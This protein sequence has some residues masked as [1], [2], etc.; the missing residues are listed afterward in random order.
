MDKAD[1]TFSVTSFCYLALNFVCRC[2]YLNME[3]LDV[4]SVILW[5]TLLITTIIKARFYLNHSGHTLTAVAIVV[6]IIVFLLSI[7]IPIINPIIV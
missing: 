7:I 6:A 1:F 3:V 4:A 5:G 2:G